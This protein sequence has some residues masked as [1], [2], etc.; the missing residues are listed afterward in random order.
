MNIFYG[1]TD[2]GHY[3]C[4]KEHRDIGYT[5]GSPFLTATEFIPNF[6]KEQKILGYTY[7]YMANRGEFRSPRGRSRSPAKVAA[8]RENGKKG[9]RPRKNKE[10]AINEK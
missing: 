6:N 10:E 1:G 9:G 8:A 2:G 3:P 4:Q 5:D 7:G